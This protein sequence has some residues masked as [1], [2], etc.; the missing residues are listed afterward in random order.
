MDVSYKVPNILYLQKICLD[1]Y[2]SIDDMMGE[3]ICSY[4]ARNQDFSEVCMNIKKIPETFTGLGSWTLKTDLLCWNCGLSFDRVPI[5]IPTYIKEKNVDNIE[6]GVC[7]NFC[8][9]NCASSYINYSFGGDFT[10]KMHNNLLYLY[11]VFTNKRIGYIKPSPAKTLM[12]IY[13]GNISANE[14]AKLIKS[15]DAN[16]SIVNWSKCFKNDV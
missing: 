8:T 15:F 11:Y 5:F 14:Y 12:D 16:Y 3:K 6:F 9:F 2:L 7:G 10:W 4:N 1:D 13:G